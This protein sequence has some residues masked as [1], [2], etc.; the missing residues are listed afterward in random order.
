MFDVAF[1]D[2]FNA[3]GGTQLFERKDDIEGVV[4]KDVC[5]G[6]AN[7]AGLADSP[8]GADKDDD[9]CGSCVCAQIEGIRLQRASKAINT[10]IF[11]M[12]ARL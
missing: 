12:T 10:I 8:T 1:T 6:S 2:A 4:I 7:G 11:L 3:L 9:C 5:D